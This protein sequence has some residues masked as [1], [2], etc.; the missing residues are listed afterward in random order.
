MHAD[1][2]FGAVNCTSREHAAHVSI[3][4][5][6]AMEVTSHVGLQW[7]KLRSNVKERSSADVIYR[8]KD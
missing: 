8:P 5:C 7:K 1:Q 4:V 2:R 3:C 6:G